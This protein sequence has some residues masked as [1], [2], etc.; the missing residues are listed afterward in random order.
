MERSLRF[1]RHLFV[2]RTSFV[3]YKSSVLLE[4]LPNMVETCFI[5]RVRDRHAKKTNACLRKM[6]RRKNLPAFSWFSSCFLFAIFKTFFAINARTKALIL[7]AEEFSSLLRVTT[8]QA[9]LFCSGI[10]CILRPPSSRC[11]SFSN[12]FSKRQKWQRAGPG[13]T[14]ESFP[15]L[16]RRICRAAMHQ[17]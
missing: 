9:S 10:G 13:D 8:R 6:A 16:L 3:K 2:F 11:A 7:E 15:E 12:I 1:F 5:I 4:D 14:C 17:V